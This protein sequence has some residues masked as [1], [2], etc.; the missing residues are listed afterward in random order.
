MRISFDKF[1]F[2]NYVFKEFSAFCYKYFCFFF[3]QYLC[4]SLNSLTDCEHSFIW[5]VTDVNRR[6]FLTRQH[7][8]KI[9]TSDFVPNA[10]NIDVVPAV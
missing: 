1:I 8:F 6:Q 3:A 9:L 10:N 4:Q 5:S 7:L 2:I